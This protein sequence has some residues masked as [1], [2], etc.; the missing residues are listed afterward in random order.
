MGEMIAD[1]RDVLR[2]NLVRAPLEVWPTA[3]GRASPT[4][5]RLRPP[6]TPTGIGTGPGDVTLLD[7]LPHLR[8]NLAGAPT[9]LL[10]ALSDATRLT[11]DVHED[12]D[13]VTLTIT[14][15]AGDLPAVAEAALASRAKDRR[16]LHL[17]RE[18]PL[19]AGEGD[20]QRSVV[21]R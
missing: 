17:D 1:K 8:L 20:L 6:A 12:S 5:T 13:D 10:R 4:S 9:P 11:I 14:M 2:R 19:R 7:R 16:V 18:L 21:V 15:P 3:A